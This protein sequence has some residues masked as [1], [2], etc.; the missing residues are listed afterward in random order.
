M[1][2]KHLHS[3]CR[4]RSASLF[5][6]LFE[7]PPRANQGFFFYFINLLSPGVLCL[8]L[9]VDQSHFHWPLSLCLI[10]S[11][12]KYWFSAQQASSD[13]SAWLGPI[14]SEV[15]GLEG[16]EAEMLTKCIFLLMK[17]FL[18]V[19][20]ASYLLHSFIP[21]MVGLCSPACW[22]SLL[23]LRGIFGD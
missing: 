20:R 5:L 13:Y 21:T 7:G 8:P 18:R 10:P 1:H 3:V 11:S 17:R 6:I 23:F 15:G 16:H 14:C 19:S 4:G 12:H 22:W 2:A 9:N